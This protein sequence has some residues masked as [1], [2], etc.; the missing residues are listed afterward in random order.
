MKNP[1]FYLF[2]ISA[3]SLSTFAQ[4]P[5][6]TNL[7][8]SLKYGYWARNTNL[9]ANLSG[10]AFSQNWQAGGINNI[11]LGG[12]FSN[13]AD[14]TKGKGV[15]SNDIQLQLGTLT[16]YQKGKDKDNRKNLDRLFA[17]TKYSKKISNKLNWFAAASLLS[18][19]LNGVDYGNAKRPL[20]S[21]L[22]APAFLTEG[23]GIE[24]KPN[25][26]FGLSLGGATLRQTLIRRSKLEDSEYYKGTPKIFGVDPGKNA[27]WEGG[28]QAVAAYDK[29][30]AKNVNM[31]WRWQTFAPYKFNAFDH[32]FNVLTSIKINK[33]VNLN[34]TILGL[35]DWDQTGPKKLKPWQLN[36]GAN[37]GF[38]VQL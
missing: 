11:V 32:N 7:S 2:F 9:G 27:R 16:N 31:K 25:K 13:R 14:F 29:N 18:Q 19:M 8:D 35:Y 6:L 1:L 4:K 20:I 38:A 34:A 36:G 37:F 26:H 22:F 28:F 12:I 33:Y 21:T 5:A 30:I 24:Y 15:W 17:E 10:A 3:F 23:L